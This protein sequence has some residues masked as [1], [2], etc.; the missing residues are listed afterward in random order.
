MSIDKKGS[1]FFLHMPLNETGRINRV[2]SI[3]EYSH[4]IID[5]F[6]GMFLLYM[7]TL[8]TVYLILVVVETVPAFKI[9]MNLND[10]PYSLLVNQLILVIDKLVDYLY[11]LVIQ[12]IR[13]R[14]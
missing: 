5:I 4:Q 14:P 1:V 2:D 3:L 6:H 8:L 12:L 10:L 7:N 13:S 9:E 11:K